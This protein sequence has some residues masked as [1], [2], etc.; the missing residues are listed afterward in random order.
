MRTIYI[1]TILA[2]AACSV[3]DKQQG[4]DGGV[5]AN[6][7]APSTAPDTTITFAPGEFSSAGS[8]MFSFTSDV[9][10][11]TFECSVDND[12]VVACTSP[13]T[14]ALADGTHSFSVRAIAPSGIADATPAEH[15]WMIDTI[16]PNTIVI[17]H[18]PAADNSTSV[19][20]E[21][22]ASEKYVTFECSL[23]GAGY[24]ACASG[25]TFGPVTDGA[26][27]FSVRATDRAGNIDPSPAV[28][29]WFVDTSTPDTQL[30]S[31][32]AG[33]TASTSATFTFVSPDAG[34]GA[35]FTCKL[36]AGA[37]VACT[38]PYTLNNLAES[39]H[40]FQVRVRDIGGNVDPSP[41]TRTWSV[42]LTPPNTT[43]NTGPSG[44]MTIASAS[45]TF[46]SNESGSTYECSLD[47]GAFAA[48][49][50]PANLTMLAQG[51]HTFSVR[52]TD[53]AA[54]VD[55]TPATR[56]W[57]VDT[58][59]PG[60]TFTQ[61]PAQGATSGPRVIYAWTVDETASMTTCSIDAATATPCTSPVAFNEPAGPH[62]F[63]VRV[64]DAAGNS[65]TGPRSWTI[66]CAAPDTLGASA[67]LHLDDAD[68]ALANDVPGGIAATLG[69]AG[70][71]EPGDPAHLA[72]GR[73]AGA[74][75]FTAAESDHV[76]WPAA[77][78]P[79]PELTIELWARPDGSLGS[80]DLLVSG[81]G[82]V[83]VRVAL[84]TPTTVRFSMT[85]IES[86]AGTPS[87]VVTS[88]PVATG[89]W[90]HVIASFAAPTLRLWVD[91]TRTELGGVTP[92]TAASFDALRL[93]GGAT[94]AYNGWL[95][96][97]WLAPMAITDDEV[98]LQR[99]CPI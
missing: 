58:I 97:V 48:C 85:F 36:D 6:A 60:I 21:F 16:T 18:P 63:T 20:F 41:A 66:A 86:G 62:Q 32:P 14:R 49:T 38:S 74:L 29:A 33:A 31:G 64:T 89:A 8:A 84:E 43:I 2:V 70:T 94:T 51:T 52:A 12:S 22:D 37:F 90:H 17:E 24:A 44:A 3:P 81:D 87:R 67:L 45:F 75:A 72:T 11:A 30:L 54:H 26:H 55:P 79:T 68:Q 9:A 88:A 50:S 40:T 78:G 27:S 1:T 92:G 93:G 82:R 83:A 77:L 10:T 71:V 34:S 47:A 65:S 80:R 46:S 28:F 98:A 13:F 57:T 91:G 42:D 35:T 7:D 15:L 73:Y 96:E 19:Q 25:D 5:D 76:S 56:T 95:D 61:G 53:A 59:P 69:D 4:G 99:Y 39:S 23:D